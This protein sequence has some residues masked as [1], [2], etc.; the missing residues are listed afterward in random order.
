[1]D[2]ASLAFS[3]D[4]NPSGIGSR[5]FIAKKDDIETIPG[6]TASPSTPAERVT[7]EGLIVMKT[8]K[9]FAEV[10]ST[11]GKGSFGFTSEG[12]KDAKIFQLTFNGK[13][14][15]INKEA[16]ALAVALLNKNCVVLVPVFEADSDVPVYVMIGGGLCDTDS[17]MSGTSGD[18]PG[19]E[20][21]LTMAI[22]CYDTIP[23]R[24]YAGTIAVDGGTFDCSDST[25]T[26]A[27]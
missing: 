5:I 24:R 18:A 4:T 15:D 10:Y 1:M 25:F 2:L 26:A 3:A 8:D 14:P 11:Q 21:G 19:S 9:V 22:T 13:F 7:L 17:D 27:T 16:A 23:G 12:E 20:K 6:L